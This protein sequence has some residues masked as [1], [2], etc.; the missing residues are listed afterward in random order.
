MKS[1]INYI[2][3][4]AD[5]VEVVGRVLQLKRQGKDWWAPCPFHGDK[6]PSF[7]VSP[8]GFFKCFGCGRKGDVIEFWQ[9]FHRISFPEAARQVGA[10]YG[11]RFDAERPVKVYRRY[12]ET[13]KPPEAWQP[14]HKD[15]PGDLW[16]EKAGKFMHWAFE[17]IWDHPGVL[18]FLAGRGIKE[19]TIVAYGLGWNS[20]KGGRDLYRTRESWGLETIIGENGKPRRLWLPVGLV[21]PGFSVSGEIIKLRIRRPDPLQFAKGVRYCFVPGGVTVS[22]VYHPDRSAHVVVESDLDGLLVDQEAGDLVG[23]AVLGSASVKPDKYAAEVLR[24]SLHILG[25]LD[26]DKAGAGAWP[27]WKENFKE[28]VRWPVPAGKDPGEFWQ[29]S[30]AGKKGSGDANIRDWIRAGLPAGLRH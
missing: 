19:K 29:R 16:K 9:K 10:M 5:I 15:E 4:Q 1:N 8:Q 7:S 3:E 14:E 2:K 25:A 20:G 26:N 18:E 13:P 6:D 28:A 17:Q 12:P 24:R 30:E 23:T 21:I 22:T 27:W 11:I